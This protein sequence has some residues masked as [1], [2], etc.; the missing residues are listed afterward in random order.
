MPV[1][2]R[3]RAGCLKIV[4]AVRRDIP[5]VLLVNPWIHDFAAYDFWAKPAGL[6]QLAAILLQHGTTVSYIDCL[7][8]FH[9]RAPAANPAG[10]NGR[11]AYLKTTLPRPPGLRDVPRRFSR[12][13]VKTRWF[14]QDLHRLPPPDLVLVTSMMAYWYPGVQEAIAEIKAIWPRVPL[15]LG[16]VYAT[17]W[18]EH[19][20]RTSGADAVVS[21]AAEG[22]ILDLVKTYTGFAARPVFDAADPDSWPYPAYHLESAVSC[23]PLLTTRGCPFACAYCAASLLNPVWMRRSPRSVLEE[24]LYWH[25]A[26]GATDFV[27]YDDALLVDAP[28]HL[29]PLLEGIIESGLR[30]RF[31]TPNALHLRE[32]D[33]RIAR[34]MARA[35]FCTIRLGIET[36]DFERR[37]GLDRKLYRPDF[38]AGLKALKDAGF[39]PDQIGAYLL[40]G[41]PG[42]ALSEVAASITALKA[43]GVRPILAHYSPIPGTALWPAAKAS[44]RYDLASDPIFTNNAIM[45]C[46][47]SPFSW[48]AVSRLKRLAAAP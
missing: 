20:R 32:I 26:C 41:L 30:L 27:F 28:R 40:V 3:G 35:G 12:Y 43:C 8:R 31:H 13:G 1:Y 36:M 22:R 34:L 10:R 25:T 15:V 17:L 23:I 11:G 7:N 24:I 2:R 33:P 19:A 29:A 38:E 44:S 45:P 9:P 42:Q 4:P 16:G 14:R 47:K 21:G 5:H 6:L 39:G 46:R 37:S 18:R 48:Q